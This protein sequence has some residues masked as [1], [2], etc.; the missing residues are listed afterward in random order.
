M[1]N[2]AEGPLIRELR[3]G[4]W[5]SDIVIIGDLRESRVVKLWE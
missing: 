3:I 5:A 2:A 4:H 1:L